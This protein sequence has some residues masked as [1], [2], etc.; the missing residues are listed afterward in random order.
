LSR[1]GKCSHPFY[2]YIVREVTVSYSLAKTGA[3][4]LPVFQISWFLKTVNL[5]VILIMS[6]HL[7]AQYAP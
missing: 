5:F 3:I 7:P 1:N 6:L 2:I 4:P